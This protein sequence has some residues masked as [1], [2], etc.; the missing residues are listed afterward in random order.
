MF[1]HG[2]RASAMMHF[3]LINQNEAMTVLSF[4]ASSYMWAC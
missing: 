3:G 2:E 1:L 4:F